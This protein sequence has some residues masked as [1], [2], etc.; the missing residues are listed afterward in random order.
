M[1]PGGNGVSTAVCPTTPV[2]YAPVGGGFLTGDSHS[3]GWTADP[4]IY[5]MGSEPER[6]VGSQLLDRWV[7]IAKNTGSQSNAV[8]SAY[9]ICAPVSARN[10]FGP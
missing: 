5:V 9:A 6:A 1:G 2:L 7:V 8:V 3:G 4:A 10:R